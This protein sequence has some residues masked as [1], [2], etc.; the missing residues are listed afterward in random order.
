MLVDGLVAEAAQSD[1]V[2]DRASGF[3]YIEQRL[4]SLSE[5]LDGEVQ[6]QVLDG[7]REQIQK[8]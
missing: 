6:R 2:F 7:T 4:Q 5:I 1:D 3:A 8:W